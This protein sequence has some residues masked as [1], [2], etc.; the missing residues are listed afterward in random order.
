M[1]ARARVCCV[2]KRARVECVNENFFDYHYLYFW[3]SFPSTGLNC[4]FIFNLRFLIS[5]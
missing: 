2:C 4:D 5:F 3:A 1:R